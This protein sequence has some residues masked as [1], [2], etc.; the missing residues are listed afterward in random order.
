MVNQTPDV[1]IFPY[2]GIA[3]ACVFNIFLPLL[4][5]HKAFLT[6]SNVVK[7]R[8]NFCSQS[9]KFFGIL[10]FSRNLPIMISNKITM[11]D[12][13]GPIYLVPLLGEGKAAKRS[14]LLPGIQIPTPFRRFL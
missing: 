2:L 7:Y 4:S 13:T 12:P 9:R 10:C 5:N 14:S 1:T 8:L 6:A 3:V 11:D